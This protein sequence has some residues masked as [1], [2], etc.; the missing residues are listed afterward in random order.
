[1]RES[2]SELPE[3]LSDVPSFDESLVSTTLKG[4]KRATKEEEIGSS[5]KRSKKNEDD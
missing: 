1:M 2:T 4:K 5:S 3:K